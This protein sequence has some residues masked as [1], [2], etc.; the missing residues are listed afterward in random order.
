M[1]RDRVL[2]LVSCHLMVSR[3]LGLDINQ[4]SGSIADSI[5]HLT[6]LTY[7]QVVEMSCTA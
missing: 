6:S 4:L 1:Y 5:G 2:A 3:A 7:A